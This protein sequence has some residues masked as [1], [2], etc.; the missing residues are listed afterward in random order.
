ME[1]VKSPPYDLL[2]PADFAMISAFLILI[3]LIGKMRKLAQRDKYS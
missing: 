1:T 3:S 2:P